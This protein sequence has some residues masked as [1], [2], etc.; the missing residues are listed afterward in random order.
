LRSEAGGAGD[1]AD[2]DR[3]IYCLVDARGSV[4]AEDGAESYGSAVAVDGVSFD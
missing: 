1:E 3:I 4:Y 2:V